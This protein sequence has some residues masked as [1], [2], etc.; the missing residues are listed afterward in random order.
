MGRT[1]LIFGSLAAAVLALTQLAKWSLLGFDNGLDVLTALIVVGLLGIG[2]VA[3]R[4]IMRRQQASRP[5]FDP[6]NAGKLGISDREAEV[7]QLMAQGLSNKEIGQALYISE[8]TVK[9]HVSQ[10]LIKLDAK[11][12]S[13]AI[14]HAR[15]KGVLE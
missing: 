5:P 1:V 11:R 8:S 9:T 3:H 10:L 15:A 6:A 4:L 7:L 12:R 13:Q 14:A 2:F